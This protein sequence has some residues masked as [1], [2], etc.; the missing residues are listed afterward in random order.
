M[1]IATPTLDDQQIQSAVQDELSWTPEV[2]S[3]GIGVSVSDGVVTLAGEVREYVTRLNAKHAALR[4][5][6]VTA[7]VDDVTVHPSWASSVTEQDI[8]RE[9]EHALTWAGNVPETVKA[10]IRGH[11]VTL[12]GA[13]TWN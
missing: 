2:E 7:I 8:A 12:T 5:R 6:G 4:V 1:T 3:A 10:E 9:V 13:V 11:D